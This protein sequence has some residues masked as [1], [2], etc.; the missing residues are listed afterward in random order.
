MRRADQ[1]YNFIRGHPFAGL[2]DYFA[3]EEMEVKNKEII[4]SLKNTH[5]QN[6]NQF[7]NLGK[8]LACF[9]EILIQGIYGGERGKG[10]T[11]EN[12]KGFC[13]KLIPDLV[14]ENRIWDSKA[15]A[16]R[17]H[18]K[19]ID[20]QIMKY[21]LFQIKNEE[22]PIIKMDIFRHG[23]N[24][25]NSKF[26][27]KPLKELIFRLTQKTKSL[28]SLD[29]S[30]IFEYYRL[31]SKTKDFK[32]RYEKG[33]SY[34]KIS[35]VTLNS[36][37]AYPEKSLESIGMDLKDIDIKKRRFPSNVTM[38]GYEINSFPVLIIENK[39]YPEKWLEGFKRII[40][41]GSH[42]PS[43]FMD[44]W[45][46]KKTDYGEGLEPREDDAPF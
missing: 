18:I 20:D 8:K 1:R 13:L 39:N 21:S 41:D 32:L 4:Y 28:I 29:L 45:N 17:Q 40:E 15:T 33:N 38:D 10:Y 44:L 9:Y 37:L 43:M 6:L 23:I 25:L 7:Q 22:M 30:I 27:D 16:S 31:S 3:S 19:L 46:T 12:D 14:S 5:N 2:E 42:I 11:L 35:S 24:H 26:A 34:T 36:L